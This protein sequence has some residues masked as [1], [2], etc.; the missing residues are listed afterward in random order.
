MVLWTT[1]R[2][3]GCCAAVDPHEVDDGVAAID[4]TTI[5]NFDPVRDRVAT[6]AAVELLLYSHDDVVV[7]RHDGDDAGT[8]TAAGSGAAAATEGRT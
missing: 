6:I 3:G 4:R 1:S 7:D 2:C 5:P 8:A